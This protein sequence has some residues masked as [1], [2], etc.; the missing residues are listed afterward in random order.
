MFRFLSCQAVQQLRLAQSAVTTDMDKWLSKSFFLDIWNRHTSNKTASQSHWFVITNIQN[1]LRTF[2]CDFAWLLVLFFPSHFCRKSTM[3]QTS[4][5]EGGHICEPEVSIFF[6]PLLL[7]NSISKNYVLSA[8][9]RS[10]YGIS[11]C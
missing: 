11:R 7:H 9:V 6:L 4:R 8:G 1:A 5:Q 10:G 2:I 3:N